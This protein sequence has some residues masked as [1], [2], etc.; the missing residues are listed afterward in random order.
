MLTGDGLTKQVLIN[1]TVMTVTNGMNNSV[2][3][4]KHA[5]KTVLLMVFLLIKTKILI[6]LLLRVINSN[7]VS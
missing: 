5:L 4:Q 7:L 2:Q 6:M 3:I 1:L